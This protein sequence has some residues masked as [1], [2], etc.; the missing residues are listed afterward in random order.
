MANDDIIF[1]TPGWDKL[2]P[3]YDYPDDLVLFYFKDNEFNNFFSCHPIFSRK[4]MN[5]GVDFSPGNGYQITKCDNTIWDVMPTNR[6]VYLDNIEVEH[7][8][9]KDPKVYNAVSYKEDNVEYLK[10][11]A[12]VTAAPQPE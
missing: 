9:V 5:L 8:Q 7:S 3:Y 4:V 12:R 1:K 10:R 2:I 6:R 11:R